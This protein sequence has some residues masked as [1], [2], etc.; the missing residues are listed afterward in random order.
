MDLLIDFPVMSDDIG[1]IAGHE[2]PLEAG[3]E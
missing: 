3:V 2:H 1:G